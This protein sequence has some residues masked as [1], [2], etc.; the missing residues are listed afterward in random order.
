MAEQLINNTAQT[1]NGDKAFASSCNK[2]LD[3]FTQIVRSAPVA[4]YIDDFNSAWMEDKCMATQI[5]MNLRDIRKG[6]GE[7]LIPI[8]LLVHLKNCLSTDVYESIIR[9]VALEYGCWKDLLRVYE[10]HAK[11]NR[12][13]SKK[14]VPDPKSIEIKLFAQQLNTDYQ[15]ILNGNEKTAISLCAKWAPSENTHFNNHP[16]YMANHIAT[17]MGLSMKDYRLVLTKLRKHLNILE[18]LMATGQFELIDFSKIPSVAMKKYA[19]VFK[20]DTNSAGIE[21]DKRKK[22]HLSY[23][24]YLSKLSR[25]ETKVN[26]TGIQPHELVGA[27][28]HNSSKEEDTLI[29]SQWKELIK[30]VKESG[31]FNNTVAISDVSGS[32]SGTPMEVSIALGI[33]VSQCTT[34]PYHGK[35]CTFDDNPVWHNLGFPTLKENVSSLSKAPWGG[36]TNLRAVFDLILRDAIEAE[37]KPEFMVKTLFIF[38]DMQ[39]NSATNGDQS[40]FEYAREQYQSVGYE[41]PNIICWNLRTSSSKIMPVTHEENGVVMLSGFS[42]ELLK[43][44]LDAKEFTPI[45][46]MKHV[47]EPYLV[48]TEVSNCQINQ[49]SSKIDVV[50]L[51][52]AIKNSA[53]KEF[54]KNKPI[55]KEAPSAS[56]D[57][58]STT[59]DWPDERVWEGVV[60]N[61]TNF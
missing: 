5:L 52:T 20:R 14:Y 4:R 34:G 45:S 54:T 47:L 55:S 37:L 44:I 42:A 58:L 10:I 39:F 33:L 3:F 17:E 59:L 19:N 35:V 16:M 60:P 21:S 9:K 46:M 26:V 48:P 32:M 2:C 23:K 36:S 27:Y 28:L 50:H 15:A 38:T 11:M 1:E 24:E 25:G 40:T 31:A 22:L 30:R 61:Q 13:V 18:M 29:E 51:E 43:C 56:S 57:T 8:A 6:K 49:L 41:L 53:I 12:C 7:K